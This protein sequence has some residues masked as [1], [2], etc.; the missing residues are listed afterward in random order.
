MRLMYKFWM[1]AVLLMAA[2]DLRVAAEDAR[3]LALHERW[4][5]A[6]G[7]HAEGAFDAPLVPDVG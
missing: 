2:C 3:H 4:L 5:R 1:T 6:D 7:N